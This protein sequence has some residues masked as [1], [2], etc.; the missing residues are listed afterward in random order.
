VLGSEQASVVRALTRKQD[1]Q[2]NARDEKDAG[3]VAETAGPMKIN[4]LA[5]THRPLLNNGQ[6]TTSSN[7]AVVTTKSLC[8]DNIYHI[9]QACMSSML[10]F[11]IPDL[12]RGLMF[13]L[14]LLR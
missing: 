3:H 4:V 6:G 14:V 12:R 11:S 10:V 1:L 5:T 8:F 2:D 7:M 9:P 13:S